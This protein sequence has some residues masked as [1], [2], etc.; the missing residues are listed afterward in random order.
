MDKQ[1]LRLDYE[2]RLRRL[3]TE[4]TDAQQLEMIRMLV[5]AQIDKEI[6]IQK[7]TKTMVAFENIP[8]KLLIKLLNY[9]IRCSRKNETEMS[10]ALQV[11]QPPSSNDNI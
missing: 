1:Q 7:N 5:N 3:T 9:A 4:L 8:N 11:Y 10:A 6:L 2:E